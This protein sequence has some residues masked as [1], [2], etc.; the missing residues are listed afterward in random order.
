MKK[1]VMMRVASV[2]LV[3]VLM[4]SSVISGTF[5]KYVTS[6]T[7][8]DSARVAKWGV[9]VT[10]EGTTFAETYETH[11]AS[12]SVGAN[13]VFASADVVAPGTSKEMAHVKLAG[14]PEVAVRVTYSADLALSTNWTAGGAYYCPIKVTVC[15]T[16]LNGMD[17]TS[18]ADFEAAVEGLIA[19][20]SKEYPAGTTDLST[21]TADDLVVTWEWPFSTGA[22]NDVKDT[23]LGNQAVVGNPATIALTVTA[24]VTQ[25]D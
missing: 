3:L 15:G 16:T 21:K 19:S 7:G 6:G 22:D 20:W 18:T 8:T 24:T 25:I 12:A 14:T 11:D 2:M 17:Y 9:T 1:N 10:A 13:S 4:T 5:A 23:E